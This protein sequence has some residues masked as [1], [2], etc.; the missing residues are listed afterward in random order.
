M[1]SGY[2]SM[3]ESWSPEPMLEL[4]LEEC[5][6]VWLVCVSLYLFDLFVYE[7]SRCIPFCKRGDQLIQSIGLWVEV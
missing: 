6:Q 7:P 3:C 4:L 5:G 1:W 2:A